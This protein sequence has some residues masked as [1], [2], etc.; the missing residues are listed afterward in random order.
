M[1]SKRSSNFAYANQ[2]WNSRQETKKVAVAAAELGFRPPRRRRSRGRDFRIGV[3]TSDGYGRFTL[4]ILIG[5]EDAFG[6][7]MASV[8]MCDT[9]DDPIREEFYLESLLERGVDGI[10][11][12]GKSNDPRPSLSEVVPIPVVY[13]FQPSE[14]PRDCSLI[15]DDRHVGGLAVDHLRSIGRRA[16]VHVS[17]PE[18]QEAVKR[19]LAGLTAALDSAGLEL[20]HPP[21]F[22]VWSERAGREAVAELLDSRTEFD[23]VFCASDQLARG[24]GTGLREAGRRV[25]EEV[26][27]VG[28][29]NW[30]AIEEA[31]RP[32]LTTVDLELERLGRQA[33]Q[34]LAR[35]WDG[36]ELPAGRHELPCRLVRRGS[37]DVGISAGRGR[38]R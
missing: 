15:P 20:A 38:R 24:V 3:I 36:K 10:I 9:R 11:V 29:D 19:R 22:G 2:A 8:M 21:V 16:I 27:V 14:D 28:V 18:R 25:P 12:T 17:G 33:A 30:T 4:P 7:G 35:A 31:A 37:T 26:A 5:A 34:L 32:P 1:F 23:A 13:A 6:P